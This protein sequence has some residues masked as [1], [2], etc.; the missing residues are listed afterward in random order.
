MSEVLEILKYILPSTVVFFTTFYLVKRYFENE[1]NRRRQEII[2]SSKN[3]VTPLRLQAY[4]RLILFLE[5]ISPENLILRVNKNN[6]TSQQLHNE[7]LSAIRTEFEH[8]L[9]QQ[10]YVSPK[11]WESLKAAKSKTVHLINVTAENIKND[12]PAMNLSRAILESV[13]ESDTSP[14]SEAMAILKKEAGELMN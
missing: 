8:N 1:D 9:S 13:I 6:I 3:M 2:L 10:I 5:R 12:S 11:V 7:M 14:V 4:E